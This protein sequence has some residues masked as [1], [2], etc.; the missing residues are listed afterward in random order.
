MSG[1]A[2]AFGNRLLDVEEATVQLRAEIGRLRRELDKALPGGSANGGWFEV[3]RTP[4]AWPLAEHP[5]RDLASLGP[6]DR[7]VDDLVVVQA[8]RG[9]SFFSRFLFESSAPNFTGA[10]NLL[11]NTLPRLRLVRPDGKE[12]PDVSVIIP[13]YGQLSY[14]LN[15]LDSLLSHESRYSAEIIVV[16]DRSLDGSSEWLPGVDAIRY[17]LQAVNGGFIKS[18]N[19]GGSLAR[20]RFVLILN[21]DTRVVGGWL[22]ALLD[23]FELFP[24][25][26]LVG[27]KMYYPDGSLQEAGGI[28]WRDGSCWNY[29]RDDDP[30]R[31]QYA[32]ARQVDYV[33]GCS[34]VLPLELWRSLGGFDPLYTPA[35]CEDADLCLRI[36]ARGREVWLQAQ[37][38]VVHYE[39]K[40]S[41]TDIASGVKANQVVNTH[42]LYLRWRERLESHRTNAEAP[43]FERERTK[44]RRMLVVDATTPTPKQDAGSVQTVLALQT[45][46]RLGYKTHFVAEHNWLFQSDYTTDL[47]RQGIECAYAPFDL[48]MP[49]YIRQYGHLFDV[50]LVYRMNVLGPIISDIRQHAP[51]AILLFH[52]ADLHYLRVQRRA[53]LENSLDGLREAAILKERELALIRAA[54]C[55]ITHSTVEAEILKKEVPQAPVMVW[56]LMLECFGT[57]VPFSARKDICF[58]GGFQHWPNV[59]AVRYFVEDILPLIRVHEPSIRFIIAGAR[60]TQEVMDL[61]G[62]GVDVIGMIDDL[63]DLFDRVRV[64]VCP[65]RVGAG[66]KGKILS[67]LSYGVP[68]VSTSVGIEGTGLENN[69]HAIVADIA[70]DFAEKTIYLYH[71]KPTW[72]RLSTAGQN[73]VKENFSLE[74]GQRKLGEAV[75]RGLQRKLGLEAL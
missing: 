66:A 18:C 46:Q 70:K 25:A 42:K 63:R 8:Q 61:K 29:G 58:L 11:N 60:P 59:D 35:Y 16:D 74:L 6:Y 2:V 72:E 52:L 33:S 23:S 69:V 13:V 68:I 12:T 36:A 15:C 30:N 27:S 17:H 44:Q 43:Y 41:G 65:L 45:S 73:I 3:P 55:T 38:R 48:N 75:R 10:V 57:H 7:R 24:R 54:D 34:V 50:I 21:N 31:P 14:T 53:D 1:R 20:G 62:D 40:T 56:P 32:H 37:S 39:G 49:S 64:F 47:Q 28:I 22:D 9:A 26:G 5:E 51:Q 4:H 19:T 71:N 67:A